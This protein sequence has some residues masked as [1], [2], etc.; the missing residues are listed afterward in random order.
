MNW[1]SRVT[2]ALLLVSGGAAAQQCPAGLAGMPNCLPPDHPSSPYGR[3]SPG[4]SGGAWVDQF[5]AVAMGKSASGFTAVEAQRSRRAAEKA[6]LRGCREK[7]GLDC[8][9]A[10][11]LQNQCGAIVWGTDFRVSGV[12][13]LVQLAV[14]SGM[15]ECSSKSSDC[16]V[17]FQLCSNAMRVR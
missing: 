14:E 16:Q 7:G 8:R 12:G 6:A 1:L 9:I 2:L 3:T 10:L 4:R 15:K 5:A 11:S 13:P 17:F